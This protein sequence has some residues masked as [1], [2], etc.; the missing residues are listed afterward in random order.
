M[1]H[2]QPG[3][4]LL[5]LLTGFPSRR[6]ISRHATRNA[7]ALAMNDS[8]HGTAQPGLIFGIK[9]REFFFADVFNVLVH[10]FWLRWP[11][12]IGRIDSEKAAG[13]SGGSSLQNV[14]SKRLTSA[15]RTGPSRAW[16]KIN[17]ANSV[18]A[19][20]LLACR[21]RDRQGQ[22]MAIPTA[23]IEPR[24]T[25]ERFGQKPA[26]GLALIYVP[27]PARIASLSQSA[28]DWSTG[29]GLNADGPRTKS[30]HNKT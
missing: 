22:V 13:E 4:G 29:F 7:A 18:A 25:L 21:N 2:L 5:T 11:S 19:N 23:V 17:N 27:R 8:R 9:L 26:C 14:V 24:D 1:R 6:I 30:G 3:L 12:R 28:A 15:Y 16:L 20:A 10:V